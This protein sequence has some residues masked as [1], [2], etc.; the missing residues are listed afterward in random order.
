VRKPG[1]KGIPDRRNIKRKEKTFKVSKI[2]DR[3]ISPGSNRERV[4]YEG[5]GDPGWFYS[6]V[7]SLLHF[8]CHV[9]LTSM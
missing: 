8:L 5:G 7:H 1:E 9:H 4:K 3:E 6:F 2:Q